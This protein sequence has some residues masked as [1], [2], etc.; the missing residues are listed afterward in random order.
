MIEKSEINVVPLPIEEV[1]AQI[2]KNWQK[3]TRYISKKR[4]NLY[5]MKMRMKEDLLNRS[6]SRF[7]GRV[8]NL[9]SFAVF[10]GRVGLVGLVGLVGQ[11]ISDNGCHEQTELRQGFRSGFPDRFCRF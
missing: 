4:A 1:T 3:S 7:Y 9:T 5:L 10:V 11:K 2:Q 8:C 6:F